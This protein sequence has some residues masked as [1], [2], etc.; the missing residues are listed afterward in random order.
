MN[1]PIA[2]TDPVAPAGT[3]VNWTPAGIEPDFTKPPQ[4]RT[5]LD[6]R[7]LRY[8]APVSM[9]IISGLA[10]LTGAPPS[11]SLGLVALGLASLGLT[12][13]SVKLDRRKRSQLDESVARNRAEMEHLADRV[14][15]LQESEERFRGLIDTL[16]DLVIH[17]DRAGR[18]V[19][20]N[21][22]F[23]DVMAREPRDLVGKT[24]DELGI[25]I[26]VVPD[27]AFT[28]GDYLSST[29]VEIQTPSGPRW[30]SWIELSVR[31]KESQ[32]ASH[33]AI[34]RDITSRK[35]AESAMLRARERAE[36]ASQ[37]KSR[38]LA[39]VSHEIRTPMNGI[40]GMAKLLGDTRLSQEQQTYVAAVKTSA[41]SLLALIEDLLDYS[42]IEA[43][44]F[45]PE[46]QPMSPRELAD[47]VVELLAARAYEKG[48]GL[49]CHV[50][51]DMPRLISADP[52]RVRQ[53]LLNLIG[54][55]I[56]FTDTG[57][58]AVSVTLL[59]QDQQMV[60]FS[61]T[62]TGEG[63]SEADRDR[64]FEEFEQA[65]S[66]PTRTHGGVG[67]GLAISRKLVQSMG[68]DI[69]V[70]LPEEGG[71]AFAFTVPAIEAVEV[72]DDAQNDLTDR[73][74]LILSPNSVEA[75]VV[76][77]S[78]EACGG[79]AHMAAT[80]KE[81]CA[82]GVGFTAVLVDAAIESRR[83][84][85]LA[86]LRR[87][88]VDVGRA[89]IMISPAERPYLTDYK[90]HGYATFLARPIR[91]ATLL[92][93]LRSAHD[94]EP[95]KPHAKAKTAG[96]PPAHRKRAAR[97]LHVL[98]AEDNAINALLARAAL[99]K[100]GHHVESVTDGK[101]AVDLATKGG[102]KKQFDLVL[103]DLHMPV[104]DGMDAIAAIR[105]YEK[106]KAVKAV[107]IVVLT[108]DSQE[109]TRHTVLAHG[110]TGF[111][112]KPMDPDALVRA[113]ED[114]ATG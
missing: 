27:A 16:G 71:S 106:R 104:M 13:Q 80:A 1:A 88:G 67:L 97:P 110:A 52:G 10:H 113:V 42:K 62:D 23:A 95:V 81:A 63:I 3:S 14:W 78:I 34:A 30:F 51:P 72:A 83:G 85:V 17:R 55:A 65:D 68:G 93:V 112:S 43:G 101:T 64:I 4:Q 38:F 21:R 91:S 39:T 29:D 109:A 107:P 79:V 7:M 76:R 50:A 86:H 89:I 33:R 77:Q 5:R 9:L 103:M 69:T 49:A 26:G 111:V 54:N 100:A 12:A 74:Y 35:R 102:G 6:H 73:T 28:S 94:L 56:K 11:L 70:A 37:A 40:M 98:L 15:E 20:A 114:H 75:G 82:L 36:H 31:D 53:V 2:K 8:V 96:K 48:I 58:V 18:L 87:R 105:T 44:R 99:T 108:A 45:E 66:T 60:R 59:D 84:S 90:L 32:T 24:L 92:R 47:G 46:P 25:N 19:Y 57:G 61:V 41:S 22:V